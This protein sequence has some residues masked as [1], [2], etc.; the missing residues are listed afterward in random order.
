[1]DPVTISDRK[2]ELR[3]LLATIKAHPEHDCTR[4]RKR[5]R[6]LNEMIAADE[7]RHVR[8]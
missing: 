7:A 6:I 4:E 1:M 3:A 8:A 2:N 5:V